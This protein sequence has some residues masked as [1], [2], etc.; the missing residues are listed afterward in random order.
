[1]RDADHLDWL[2][3]SGE[4][5]NN[6]RADRFWYSTS[7]ADSNSDFWTKTQDQYYSTT[8][9]ITAFGISKIACIFISPIILFFGIRSRQKKPKSIRK[10][11]ANSK[12][13][14]KLLAKFTDDNKQ[15]SSIFKRTNQ[16]DDERVEKWPRKKRKKKKKEQKLITHQHSNN[17]STKRRRNR[18]SDIDWIDEWSCARA[19]MLAHSAHS[20]HSRLVDESEWIDALYARCR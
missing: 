19:L 2:S 10:L 6:C 9:K 11:V 15:Y 5:T 7:I 16:S 14:L 8:S 3:S 12:V 17:N 13:E 1:M 20:V 4:I 18:K